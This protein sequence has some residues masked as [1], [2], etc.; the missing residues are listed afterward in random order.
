[1]CGKEREPEGGRERR[2]SLCV[3]PAALGRSGPGSGTGELEGSGL[4]SLLCLPRWGEGAGDEVSG[5]RGGWGR[6]SAL[7][8]A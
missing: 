8:S 2:R 3:G 6:G 1:M 4:P 7:G 5:P